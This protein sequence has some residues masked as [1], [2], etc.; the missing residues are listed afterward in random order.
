MRPITYLLD[1]LVY[2]YLNCM[3]LYFLNKLYYYYCY[4]YCYVHIVSGSSSFIAET[5]YRPD[6][7]G[8]DL[9]NVLHL[10]VW[11]VWSSCY[12]CWAHSA[13]HPS[14][15]IGRHHPVCWDSSCAWSCWPH[16]VCYSQPRSIVRR[17]CVLCQHVTITGWRH[18][19]LSVWSQ[20]ALLSMQLERPSPVYSL[21]SSW[22]WS[23]LDYDYFFPALQCRN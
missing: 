19:G 5:I 6:S 3:L 15:T 22:L 8:G 4:Y 9:G 20:N 10:D 18:R 16:D 1:I 17:H 21:M 14:W 7:G 12:I 23:W 11:C 13:Q 2:Y